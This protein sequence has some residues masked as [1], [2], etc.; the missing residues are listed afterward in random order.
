MK[1]EKKGSIINPEEKPLGWIKHY[2]AIPATYL[3]DDK[4][5]RIYFSTRDEKGRSIP[6]YIE[7]NPLDPKE[8]LYVHDRPI[9]ELGELGTFD[10]N[11]IMPSWIVEDGNRVLMYYIAWNPQVTV[12]YRLAIGLAISNDGGKTFTR[13]SKGPLSDRSADE[14][15]FNTAPCVMK[16]GDAWKLWFVSCTGWK[17]IKDWPEPF[18]NIKYAVSTDGTNWKKTG[19]TCIDYDDFTHAIGRPCVF[20]EDDVYYMLYSYRGS[21]DYRTSAETSYRLGMAT[22]TDGVSWVRRDDEIGIKFSEDGWDSMMM[23]YC[24]TYKVNGRRFLLYNGN[25]FGRTGFGYA[26]LVGAL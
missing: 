9:L 26:E 3:V 6:T 5:L 16:E 20:K 13:F 8:I 22:S 21:V 24:A 12:S 11:G 23:E 15:F 14:P 4:T 2:A 1:W 17:T 7:V 10:D 18:Y 25:G 19:V